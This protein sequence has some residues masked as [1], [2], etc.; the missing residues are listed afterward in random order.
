MKRLCITASTA[1]LSMLVLT[2]CPAEAGLIIDASAKGWYS[3]DGI[4]HDWNTNTLTG[5]VPD[6]YWSGQPFYAEFRSFFLF[7][8]TSVFGAITDAVLKL[9]LEAYDSRDQFESFTVY[10]VSTPI[11]DLLENRPPCG[12]YPP[13]DG[14][15]PP[16]PD[17]L[18]GQTIFADLGS[19]GALRT[20]DSYLERCQYR[21][22][23]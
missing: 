7:D 5:A 12:S 16:P 2:S 1:I 17:S 6:Y 4:H 11:D 19:G 23:H 18:Y 14:C 21:D 20:C 3:S 15:M 8:L 22:F 13:P 9:E 10:D